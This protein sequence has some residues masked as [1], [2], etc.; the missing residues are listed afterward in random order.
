MYYAEKVKGGCTNGHSV[1]LNLLGNAKGLDEKEARKAKQQG[2]ERIACILI[3]QKYSEWLEEQ[4]F[5]TVLLYESARKMCNQILE[6]DWYQ[7]TGDWTHGKLIAAANKTLWETFQVKSP[8][9]AAESDIWSPHS[10][11]NRS[12]L[13]L[14]VDE[15]QVLLCLQ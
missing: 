15:Y 6:R 12:V 3:L 5:A 9:P 11:R 10:H 13:D 14:S 8:K 4:D 1:S 7:A 2:M